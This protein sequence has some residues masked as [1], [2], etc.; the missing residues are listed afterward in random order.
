MVDL[1]KISAKDLKVIVPT[2]LS[3]R[4]LEMSVKCDAATLI[5]IEGKDNRAG[6]DFE[7]PYNFGF[8]LIN[9]SEK[10]GGMELTVN[11]L[12]ADGVPARTIESSD[13]GATW[14]KGRVLGRLTMISVADAAT[15]AQIPVREFS[16]DL[17]FFP[18]IAPTNTLTLD[19]E[20]VIDGS[21][22]LTVR[23]L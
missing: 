3:E 10:L 17:K 13:G 15:M 21:V 22:T 5:A 2:M 12:I 9:G 7:G 23:Y 19:Q 16:S 20:V 11:N 8:G 1:G 4:S 18:L 6:S 14:Y